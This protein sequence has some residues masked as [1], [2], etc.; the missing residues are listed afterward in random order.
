M[1]KKPLR[2]QEIRN[3]MKLNQQQEIKIPDY[4]NCVITQVPAYSKSRKS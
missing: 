2:E 1:G 4:F 3:A